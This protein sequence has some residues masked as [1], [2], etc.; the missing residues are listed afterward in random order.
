MTFELVA[1]N[2]AFSQ[3]QYL[4]AAVNVLTNSLKISHK[5]KEDFLQT[6]ISRIHEKIR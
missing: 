3:R 2:A 5:T 6:N 4:L 1:R